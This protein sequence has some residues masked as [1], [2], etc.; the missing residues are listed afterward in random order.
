MSTFYTPRPYK[1]PWHISKKLEKIYVHLVEGK[2]Q[3]I[4]R[5]YSSDEL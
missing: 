4:E 3:N 1:S 5:P 2:Y